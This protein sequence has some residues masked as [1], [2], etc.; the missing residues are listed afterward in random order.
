MQKEQQGIK[1]ARVLSIH[2]KLVLILIVNFVDML[3]IGLVKK[4]FVTIISQ[5]IV[6][7]SRGHFQLGG[8]ME[9]RV[10]ETRAVCR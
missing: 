10:F 6:E 8:G 5:L 3:C 7:C 9:G 1:V 4:T 2:S